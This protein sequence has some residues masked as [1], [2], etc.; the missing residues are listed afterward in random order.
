MLKQ[1]TS[2]TTAEVLDKYSAVLVAEMVAY[3]QCSAIRLV[4]P[5][6]EEVALCALCVVVPA[7]L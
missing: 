4:L 1:Q 5:V 2:V 3:T 6:A 7:T